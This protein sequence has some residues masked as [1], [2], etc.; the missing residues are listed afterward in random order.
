MG[1][2]P[3]LSVYIAFPAFSSWY[4]MLSFCFQLGASCSCHAFLVREFRHLFPRARSNVF[5]SA[6]S[7][8]DLGAFDLLLLL[9]VSSYLSSCVY[10]CTF[11]VPS[12]F[13]CAFSLPVHSHPVHVRCQK[14]SRTW[15]SVGRKFEHICSLCN[16]PTPSPHNGENAGG[17]LVQHT[18]HTENDRVMRE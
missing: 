13:H 5:P 14:M 11:Y 17:V 8:G 7:T 10:L 18:E 12:A 4:T 6:F 2:F 16:P 1:S 15:L 3:Y 9:R